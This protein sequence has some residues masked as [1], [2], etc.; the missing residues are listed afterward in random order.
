[1]AEVELPNHEELEEIKGKQFTR[2]VALMTGIIA[3]VLAITSLGGG[4]AT[5]EMLLAQQQAS[6]TW[7]FYQA[8]SIRGHQD[9]LQKQLLEVELAG[10]GPSITGEARQRAE[11]AMTDLANEAQRYDAEK[12][13]LEEKAKEL[14][15][16]RDLYRTKDPYFDYAEV[17]LQIAIVLSSIVIL[18]GSR[19]ILVVSVALALV[20][21]LLTLDGYTLAV[22]ISWIAGPH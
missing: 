19:Q 16:E 17:F 7:A 21:A 8:K 22:P 11:A 14:E 3:V 12:K 15:K 20:G 9:K 18:S 4:N 10:R 1:M 5:K 2:R 13:E 6:D